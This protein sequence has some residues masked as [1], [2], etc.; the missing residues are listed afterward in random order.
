MVR[1]VLTRLLLLGFAAWQLFCFVETW[2]DTTG[3]PRLAD[4]NWSWPASW[5][6]FTLLDKGDS[7]IE[8]EA[9]DGEEW[10]PM[11]LERW[12]PTRWDSGHRW[13][14]SG[15]DTGTIRAFLAAACRRAPVE[16]TRARLVT[17]ERVPEGLWQPRKKE[18]STEITSWS[19]DRPAPRVRGKVW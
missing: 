3:K 5:R 18:R 2:R 10:V 19:C 4:V 17:W 15:R 13:E 1:R 8:W 7:R 11:P 14:R 12:Y 6:M 16:K 9:W